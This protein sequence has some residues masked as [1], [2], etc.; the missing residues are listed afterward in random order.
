MEI[1]FTMMHNTNHIHKTHCN[2][3]LRR[4][5]IMLLIV[6]IIGIKDYIKMTKIFEL[7]KFIK[8][9]NLTCQMNFINNCVIS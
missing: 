2:L 1:K 8:K 6:F 7:L 3:D 4:I 5:T 9:K